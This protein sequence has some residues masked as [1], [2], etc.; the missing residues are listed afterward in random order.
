MS[1]LTVFLQEATANRWCKKVPCTTCGSKDFRQGLESLGVEK[2]I[3][4]LGLLNSEE[5]Y[6]NLNT[7]DAVF[8]WLRFSWIVSTPDDL[9]S[10]R[11]SVAWEYFNHKN[12]DYKRAVATRDENRAIEGARQSEFRK[13]KASKASHDLIKALHRGDIKA[14]QS[15]LAKGADPDADRGPSEL[16]A[17]QIARQ[18]GKEELYFPNNTLDST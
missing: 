16:T 5:F 8:K 2:V 14:I 17:R 1:D 18:F 6:K 13:A 9:E 12:D 7:I 4:G 3:I 15:L 11:G 10:I